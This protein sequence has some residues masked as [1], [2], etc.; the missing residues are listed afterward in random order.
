MTDRP[1][2]MSPGYAEQILE[3]L[4]TKIA[5][6]AGVTLQTDPNGA[7][8]PMGASYLTVRFSPSGNNTDLVEVHCQIM[9]VRSSQNDREAEAYEN[10][11]K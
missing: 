6:V 2:L 7:W 8:G 5:G 9:S 11:D 1:A 3:E 10:E 4:R